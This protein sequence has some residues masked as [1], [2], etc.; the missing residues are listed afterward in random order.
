M[1]NTG[2]LNPGINIYDDINFSVKAD[3]N[4]KD[5]SNQSLISNYF[6][7]K[8]TVYFKY[9]T[10]VS[11]EDNINTG[12]SG[13]F[14][15]PAMFGFD[16]KINMIDS[17]MFQNSTNPNSLISFLNYFS[18]GE[19][20]IAEIASRVSTYNNF[21][22]QLQLF[23]NNTTETNVIKNFKSHYLKSISGLSKLTETVDKPFIDFYKDKITLSF[24]EDVKQS[25]NYL[26][27]LYKTLTW[28]K[29]NGKWI[30]PENV[31]R[32]DCIISISE[33]RNF[34]LIKK[35]IN[36]GTVALNMISDN[37]SRINYHLYECQFQFD[38]M[39]HTD[40]VDVSAPKISEG[41]VVNIVYKYCTMEMEKF[42]S[43]DSSYINNENINPSTRDQSDT[44]FYLSARG[45]NVS[46]MS[47]EQ[48]NSE[49]ATLENNDNINNQKKPYAIFQEQVAQ[50]V[51][52][53][54]PLTGVDAMVDNQKQSDFNTGLAARDNLQTS[55]LDT[56]RQTIVN[57][58][59]VAR[60]QLINDTINSIRS[61][62]GVRSINSPQNVYNSNLVINAIQDFT[63]IGISTGINAINNIGQ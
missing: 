39:S 57:T 11:T 45:I 63:N 30:I 49:R 40:T 18:S 42:D 17:P 2:N 62:I 27:A 19:N 60:N 44:D 53:E 37:I 59:I 13:G 28:S 9:G 34:N 35:S 38:E 12:Q 36:D 54:T 47:Q 46:E 21:I 48:K 8:R 7:D 52:D 15:D 23:F 10:N 41:Y 26:A 51:N 29:K 56:A 50:D 25:A 55:I 43:D 24:N 33:M 1:A 22:N 5:R 58:A 20:T 61:S 6:G 14:E 4:Q 32:F 3:I 16:L 31:M